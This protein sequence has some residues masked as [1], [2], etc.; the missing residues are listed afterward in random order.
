M[1]DQGDPHEPDVLTPAEILQTIFAYGDGMGLFKVFPVGS[2]LLRARREENGVRYEMPG[3]LGPP[4][5]D[6]AKQ[7]NRMSPSGIAMFIG[8]TMKRPLSVSLRQTPVITR[9]ESSR[10]C[11]R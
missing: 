3:E 8:A 2:R 10:P 4:P 11:V 5:K 7:A 9:S 1:D 6:A